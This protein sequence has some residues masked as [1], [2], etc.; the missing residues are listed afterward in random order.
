M[1][2][3]DPHDNKFLSP[4]SRYYGHFSPKNLAFNANLQEFALRVNTVC[5]LETGGKIGPNEAY[6]EI[7]KLWNQLAESHDA[8]GIEEDEE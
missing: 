3:Q 6:Q 2:A 7:K 4:R 1:A 5:N 8:L